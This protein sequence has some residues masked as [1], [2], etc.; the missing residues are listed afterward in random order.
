DNA[1]ADEVA[2]EESRGEEE[3]HHE[4]EA[5]EEVVIESVEKLECGK[6]H[7]ELVHIQ[8]DPH[9]D[10]VDPGGDLGEYPI[11]HPQRYKQGHPDQEARYDMALK[12]AKVQPEKTREIRILR[13]FSPQ[14]LGCVLGGF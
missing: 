2:G 10:P 1:F 3:K 12:L 5:H 8:L 11:G 6:T 7:H 9:H 4:Q 14:E 13:L